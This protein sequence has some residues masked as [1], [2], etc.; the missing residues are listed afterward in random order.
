MHNGHQH[1]LDRARAALHSLD[2][3]CDRESWVRLAMASKAAGLDLDE[4]ARWSSGAATYSERDTRSVW[5]SIRRGDGIGAATLF[6]LA[7]QAG[8]REGSSGAARQRPEKAPGRPQGPPQGPKVGKGAAEVW[9]RCVP[10][11]AAHEYVRVKGAEGVPLGGLRVV[12]AG[13]SLKVAG[14]PM[15]GALVVPVLPLGGGDPVSLQFIAAGAQAEAWKAAGRPTKL[16]LPAHPVEGVFVVGDIAAGGTVYL[17]EGVGQGWAIWKATGRAAVVAFGWGRVR[18]VAAELRQRDPEAQLVL[19]PDAGKEQAA[20]EIAAE[21]NASVAA[22][23][24]G[25]PQNSDMADLAQAEGVEA[26]EE[27][28]R[29]AKAPPHEPHPLADFVPVDGQVRP[30]RWVVPGFIAEGVVMIAGEPA[31]GKT[32]ALVPLALVAAHLCASNDPLRPRHWR[33]VVFISEDVSQARRV[34]AGVRDHGSPPL[35]GKLVAERFH[36]VEAQRLPPDEVDRGQF[37]RH[38]DGVEVLPLVVLD[39]R[40]AVLALDD[41]N[42]NSEA[43]RA[44]AALKQ[45]FEG[46]P[47]WIIGHLPKALAGRSEARALAMRGAGAWEADAHQTLFVV[48]EQESRFIVLGKR[49]FEPDWQELAVESES[50]DTV[51]PDEFGV[52]CTVRL[53]WGIPRPPEQSRQEAKER[54]QEQ[55]RKQSDAELRQAVRDAV[56]MA[57][58][59]GFPLT[60]E[61][62]K[63]KV[64]RKAADVARTVEALL[65]ERW[66]VEVLI[67]SRLR[68]NPRRASFLVNLSTEEHEAV[69]RGEPAPEAKLAI[70]ASMTKEAA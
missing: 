37:S 55:A 22:L 58:Q 5:Q 49:R 21:V 31:V 36:L 12:P 67:P 64:Q 63:A 20:F 3:G 35:D 44:V 1:E 65:A 40:S 42:D 2:P 8:W 34:L 51:V 60:R 69:L 26:V 46:L 33:H 48:R 53:R 28:L 50:A 70:P 13:D 68:S 4:F 45:G 59:A 56:Q 24:P 47:V 6:H 30:P 17:C 11:T 25:W 39:T 38:I 29:A 57:W 15:A 32:S 52:A 27:V 62:T 7:R 19:V 43:S 10:A 61:A 23:P 16:N 18:S 14:L 66:L 41:E 9:A 54:A